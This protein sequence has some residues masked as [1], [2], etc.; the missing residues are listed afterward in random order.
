MP[1]DIDSHFLSYS[2][3]SDLPHKFRGRAKIFSDLPHKFKGRETDYLYSGS[4][5]LKR[6]TSGGRPSHIKHMKDYC[7]CKG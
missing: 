5:Y 1:G 4:F 2:N 7:I 6:K 3:T